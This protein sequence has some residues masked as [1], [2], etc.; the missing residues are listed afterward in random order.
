LLTISRL[1]DEVL[2]AVE[3]Q[4]FVQT[5]TDTSLKEKKEQ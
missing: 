2:K 3:R 4:F 1:L 5:T